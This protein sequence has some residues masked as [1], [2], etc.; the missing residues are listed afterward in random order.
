MFDTINVVAFKGYSEE[1]EVDWDPD[2]P[3]PEPEPGL[4][5]IEESLESV[6]E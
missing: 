3:E 2:G 4:V 1:S 5:V 6:P